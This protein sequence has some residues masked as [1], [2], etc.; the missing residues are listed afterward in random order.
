MPDGPSPSSTNAS[1]CPRFPHLPLK[2]LVHGTQK[3]RA[4]RLDNPLNAA[5]A[6]STG[7][8]R[9]A[10]PFPSVNPVKILKPAFLSVGLRV[11]TKR[12]S[13]GIDRLQKHVLNNRQQFAPFSRRQRAC[14]A[15]GMD[16]RAMQGLA[17]IYIAKSRNDLLIKQKILDRCT[18]P[19]CKFFKREVQKSRFEG[20][21]TKCSNQGMR[22]FF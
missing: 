5:T 16:P 4:P 21:N 9:A 10:A 12:R 1:R 19:L 22:V 14:I 2:P 13:T 8:I 17:H 15:R 6:W 18:A 20:L 11:I 7:T 3:R